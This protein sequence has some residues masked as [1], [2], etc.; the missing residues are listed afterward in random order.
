MFVRTAKEIGLLIRDTRRRAGLSQSQLASKLR[1]SQSWVSEIETGKPGAELGLVLAL[2][3]TLGVKLDAKQPDHSPE[4][5]DDSSEPSDSDDLP[6]F[7]R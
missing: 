6:R 3:A 7:P 5:S 2:L 4:L 1:T